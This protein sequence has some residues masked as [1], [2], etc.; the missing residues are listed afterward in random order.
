VAATRQSMPLTTVDIR[1]N[2]GPPI[3]SLFINLLRK[4]AHRVK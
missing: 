3:T 1:A 4:L 2:M